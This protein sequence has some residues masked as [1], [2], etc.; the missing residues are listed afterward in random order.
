MR[1]LKATPRYR[2]A[3][4]RV[5]NLGDLRNLHVRALRRRA[6]HSTST[7]VVTG[8][9]AF[10]SV[11]QGYSTF[12]VNSILFWE[13][14]WRG[15]GSRASTN[16]ARAEAFA[17]RQLPSGRSA[18]NRQSEPAVRGRLFHRSIISASGV[19]RARQPNSREK[20]NGKINLAVP[21]S[22]NAI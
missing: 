16:R 21:V 15:R 5:I 9:H 4:E 20:V 22:C 12:P 18:V 13:V 17:E 6:T 3:D 19:T 11:V 2:S 1:S 8:P 7:H 14:L 10:H